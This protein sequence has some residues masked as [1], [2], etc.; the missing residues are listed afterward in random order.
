MAGILD[1]K[2]AFVTGGHRGIGRA[3]A[4]RLALPIRFVGLG[5]AIDDLQPFDAEAY[6]E[7]LI[8]DSRD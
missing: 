1:G 7:A 8:G 5:E 6:V 2:R 3:I 4:R